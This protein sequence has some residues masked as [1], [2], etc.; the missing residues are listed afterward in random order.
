MIAQQHLSSGG[1]G[2]PLICRRALLRLG[3]WAADPSPAGQ[4]VAALLLPPA[5]PCSPLGVH[6]V[7]QRSSDSMR[8]FRAPP[9]E[10]LPKSPKR[11][12]GSGVVAG[13]A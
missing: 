7:S 13:Q 3:R 4:H 12:A 8:R 9:Q 1:Q 11:K 10:P 2:P 5:R 6:R